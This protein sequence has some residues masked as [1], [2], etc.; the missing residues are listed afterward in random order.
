MEKLGSLEGVD[1]HQH[2]PASSRII[3]T[4]EA[5]DVSGEVEGLKRIKALPDIVLAEMV[6]HYFEDDQYRRHDRCNGG[7]APDT[8]CAGSKRGL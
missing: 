3:V 2:D 6:Y 4:L 1:V 7:Y 5:K 8:G